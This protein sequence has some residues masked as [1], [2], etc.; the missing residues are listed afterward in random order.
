M[1]LYSKYHLLSHAL[2]FPSGLR[3]AAVSFLGKVD[4]RDAM[5]TRRRTD[6]LG[7]TESARESLDTD[8]KPRWR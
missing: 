8:F 5:L 3:T 6:V 2:D 1:T 7:V 4:S